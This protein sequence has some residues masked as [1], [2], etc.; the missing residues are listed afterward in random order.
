ML[1]AAR[2]AVWNAQDPAARY[3]MSAEDLT[4]QAG[5]SLQQDLALLNLLGIHHVE[6][7]GHSLSTA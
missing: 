3:F 2:C 6:R 5:L 7:N 1:N 4:T